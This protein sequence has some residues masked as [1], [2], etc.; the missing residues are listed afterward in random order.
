MYAPYCLIRQQRASLSFDDIALEVA[1][2]ATR[3]WRTSRHIGSE[4]TNRNIQFRLLPQLSLLL[5]IQFTD[6]DIQWISVT[7]DIES[8]RLEIELGRP[9]LKRGF[10]HGHNLWL[11]LEDDGC[12]GQADDV[13]LP[14]RHHCNIGMALDLLDIVLKRQRTSRLNEEFLLIDLTDVDAAH[15]N[16]LRYKRSEA[17]IDDWERMHRYYDLV[18]LGMDPYRVVEVLEL[19][20]GRELHIHV[21]DLSGTQQAAHPVFYLE[22]LRSWWHEVHPFWKSRLIL[23]LHFQSMRLLQLVARKFDDSWICEEHATLTN[24]LKTSQTTRLMC[25]IG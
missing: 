15:I 9:Q 20:A 8:I 25:S 23:D 22:E 21:L 24:R 2:G 17:S 11:E 1:S 19:V 13:T 3:G 5:F 12:V 6:V 7:H 4:A 18:A 14:W 10:R 16:D